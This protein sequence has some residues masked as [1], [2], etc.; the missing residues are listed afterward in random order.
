MMYK[1]IRSIFFFVFLI[2]SLAGCDNKVANGKGTGATKIQEIQ[3]GNKTEEKKE[4]KP[5]DDEKDDTKETEKKEDIKK[6][7]EKTE[8]TKKE[9]KETEKKEDEDKEEKVSCIENFL[10]IG[11][12]MMN[13]LKPVIQKDTPSAK[14]EGADGK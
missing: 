12:S 10:F 7:T 3:N 1:K 8:D 14:V 2:I 11:D 9:E 5:K 6:E 4:E 13:M